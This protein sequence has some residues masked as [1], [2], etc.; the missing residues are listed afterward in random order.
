MARLA[1]TSLAFMFVEVPEPVWKMSTTNWS[2]QLPLH[3]LGRSLLD[4]PGAP[5]VEQAQRLGSRA[6]RPA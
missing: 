3:H 6:P 5:P 1:I 4:R 2:S